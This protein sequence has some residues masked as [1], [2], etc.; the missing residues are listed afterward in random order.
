MNPTVRLAIR[1]ASAGGLIALITLGLIGCAAGEVQTV[2]VTEL[3]NGEPVVVTAAPYYGAAEATSEAFAPPAATEEARDSTVAD[4]N[5]SPDGNPLIAAL[6][7]D[8][9]IIKNGEISLLVENADVA[10]DRVTQT[11]VDNGGYVLTSNTWFDDIYKSATVTIAVRSD[12]F[13]IAMRRLRD[14]SIMVLQESSSGEDVSSEF[15]DLESRLG[16][17]EATRDRIQTFLDQAKTVDEALKVNEQ[18][19]EIEAEIEQVKGRMNY[20]SGRAAF[21]TITVDLTVPQPTPTITPTPTNTP[22]PTPT[23]TPTPWSAAGAVQGAVKA[24]TGLFH[25]LIELFI[26]FGLVFAPYGVVI[27]GIVLGARA[28][29]KRRNGGSGSSPPPTPPEPEP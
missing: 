18:L 21:S 16:N 23:F 26:W 13:E 27:G 15:V 10:I 6:P 11:A 22:T 9:L 17:L 4:T 20:L 1:L 2:V 7:Q 5:A 25:G 19:A 3:L 8:R 29:M 28:F 14:I 24:Q 12:R